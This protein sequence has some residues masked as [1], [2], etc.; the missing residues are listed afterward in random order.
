MNEEK[1]KNCPFCNCSVKIKY[2]R[3]T[4]NTLI[5]RILHPLNCNEEKCSLSG[6]VS[7]SY[8]QK[9]NCIKSW[10]TRFTDKDTL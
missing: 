5:W 6:F 10:N 2:L 7:L 3:Y 8:D 1:L 9:Y 4:D